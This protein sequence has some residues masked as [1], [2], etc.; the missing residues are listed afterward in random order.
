VKDDGLPDPPGLPTIAWTKLS[1]S[2]TVV[3]F[4]TTNTPQTRAEFSL[5]GEYRL[6][7]T[8]SDGEFSVADEV[9]VRLEQLTF[10]TW[11]RGYFTAAE[12]TDPQVSGPDADPDGDRLTN[13][14]EYLCGTHPR[15]ARSVLRLDA[16][17]PVAS[18]QAGARLWFQ[19]AAYKSYTL[20]ASDSPGLG[21][22]QKVADLDAQPEEQPVEIPD[23]SAG[24]GPARYYR[25]VTPKQP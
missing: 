7:L 3:F 22:W 15:E 19:A 25:L 18:G 2:G 6:K 8:A 17:V 23:P 12:L 16:V 10:D 11:R 13:Y 14:Q 5:P 1:G 4:N 20:Q 24:S 9:V 21:T